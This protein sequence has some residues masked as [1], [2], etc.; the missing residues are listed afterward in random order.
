[1]E[2]DN[3]NPAPSFEEQTIKAIKDLQHFQKQHLNRQLAFEAML[4]SMLARVQPEALP[5]LLAE[6][7]A[8]CDRLATFLEPQ[9]QM[10]DIWRQWTVALENQI[11]RNQMPPMTGRTAF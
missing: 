2:N 8:A 11:N 5:G 9:H 10:P 6:Y 4:E 3:P 7:E 1:M